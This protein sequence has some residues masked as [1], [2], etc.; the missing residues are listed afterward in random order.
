MKA[1]DTVP[2]KLHNDMKGADP[3]ET[4]LDLDSEK[5]DLLSDSD[6]T[7]GQHVSRSDQRAAAAAAAP[8][9]AEPF[10]GSSRDLRHGSR[11]TPAATEPVHPPL[12]NAV[13]K[14]KR[15]DAV[16][17]RDL[18]RKRQLIVITLARLSEP[19]VQ[20]SLQVCHPIPT[21]PF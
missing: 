19:L 3:E 20:T 16:G 5:E 11:S 9:D 18:P 6:S 14:H 4:E 13:G 10:L 2:I 8:T 12:I 1:H 21:H 17:W 15:S 7:D